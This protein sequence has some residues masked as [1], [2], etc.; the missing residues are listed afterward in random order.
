VVIRPNVSAQQ[1]ANAPAKLPLQSVAGYKSAPTPAAVVAGGATATRWQ[2]GLFQR[3]TDGTSAPSRRPTHTSTAAPATDYQSLLDALRPSFLADPS[4]DGSDEDVS[5]SLSKLFP[6]LLRRS[7]KRWRRRWREQ[8]FAHLF[9]TNPA[10]AQGQSGRAQSWIKRLT[11]TRKRPARSPTQ[12][13]QSIGQPGAERRGRQ[14]AGR[15]HTQTR[16]A[17]QTSRQ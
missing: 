12:R 17:R 11:P 15:P 13:P 7:S 10:L 5:K 6:K 1:L 3:S 14:H 4:G 9:A 16:I 8:E 2:A